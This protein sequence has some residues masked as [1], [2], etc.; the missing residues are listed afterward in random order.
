[1]VWSLRVAATSPQIRLGEVASNAESIRVALKDAV[2]AGAELIVL[3]ELA[4]SGYVFTDR[5]EA[6]EAS[7]TR[8]D[9]LWS[10]LAAVLAPGVTAVVGYAE[11]AEHHLYNSA[12]VF[13]SDQWIGDYRKSHLWGA[14]AGLFEKGS[15]A[16]AL[17]EVPFGR[18]GVAICYDNEFP[19]VPRRLALGG[20]DVLA[21]PVNWPRVPRPNGER[22]PEIIQAM[23]AARSSRL[24]TVIADRVGTERGVEWTEGTAVIDSGGWVS[25]VPDASGCAVQTLVLGVRGDKSL[26]PHNDLFGDRRPHLY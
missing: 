12:A 19:E 7:I 13:T 9:P 15:I 26:P 3:P 17:F 5:D 4:T 14:E 21:L 20:A 22:P 2:A 10:E 6:A 11:R 23:A 1:M 16:G 24:A 25:A 8:D 18:L